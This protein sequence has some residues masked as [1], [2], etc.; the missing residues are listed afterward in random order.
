MRK[1]IQGN[2]WCAHLNPAAPRPAV[3]V[4]DVLGD[5]DS[6]QDLKPVEPTPV[7]PK[8]ARP[9]PVRGNEGW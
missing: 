5:L 1:T 3:R 7:L 4:V 2:L 9:L 8:G 6:E